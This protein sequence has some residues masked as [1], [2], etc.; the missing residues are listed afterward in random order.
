MEEPAAAVVVRG[1][2][3]SRCRRQIRDTIRR[4]AMVGPVGAESGGFRCREKL[5]REVLRRPYRKP[6]QVVR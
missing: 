2:A 6:T 4:G 5:R 3:C 1:Q